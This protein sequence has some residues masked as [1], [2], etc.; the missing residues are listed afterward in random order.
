MEKHTIIRFIGILLLLISLILPAS[1]TF[2]EPTEDEETKKEESVGDGEILPGQPI[3]SPF[4]EK[5]GPEKFILDIVP[6]EDPSI[7][8]AFEVNM[9]KFVNWFLDLAFY[10]YLWLIEFSIRMINW[11]YD[12]P[13]TEEMI[14]ILKEAMPALEQAVWEPLWYLVLS[15]SFLAIVLWWGMGEEKKAISKLLAILIMLALAP[16][17][18]SWFPTMMIKV[19]ASS[20]WTSAKILEKVTGLNE[21]TRKED[22]SVVVKDDDNI[23]YQNERTEVMGV[24]WFTTEELDKTVK[25]TEA[26]HK[27]DDSLWKAFGYESYLI[28]NFGDKEIGEKYFKKLMSYGTDTDARR[29]YIKK[30]GKIDAEGKADNE[31][32]VIFTA[33]GLKERVKNTMAVTIMPLVPALSMMI[34]AF[35]ILF[36]KCLA[37][38]FGAFMVVYALLALW[39]NNGLGDFVH[40]LYKTLLALAMQVFYSIVLSVFLKIWL[41]LQDPE[42]FP[43][44][45]MGGRVIMIALIIWSFWIAAKAVR[46]KLEQVQGP[47]GGSAQGAMGSSTNELETLGGAVGTATRYAARLGGRAFKL[48]PKGYG[49]ASFSKKLASSAKGTKGAKKDWMSLRKTPQAI[50]PNLSSNANAVV[51]KMSKKNLNPYSTKDRK[52]FAEQRPD[53]KNEM[54]ELDGWMKRPIEEQFQSIP[55]FKSGNEAPPEPPKAGT[56]AYIAWKQNPE[57]QRHWKIYTEARKLI[58]DDDYSRYIKRRQRRERSIFRHM[59][60]KPQFDPE[61]VPHGKVMKEYRRL[62][63][64]T[65]HRKPI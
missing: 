28:V 14:S 2:A 17:V 57:I 13:M 42:R 52:V 23:Q 10:F 51:Q 59:L 32:F 47:F 15:F 31:D 19:N 45:N 40:Y 26:I 30:V 61:N 4:F 39:P 49:A 60:P 37:V 8:E 53:L 55:D 56:S 38:G 35:A 12:V 3:R 6:K 62:L 1:S 54:N 48:A 7:G 63:N 50:T 44:L 43:N 18:F 9:F 11:A 58:H 46:N 29:E 34:F 65:G 16:A 36:Q 24:Q 33:D 5:Y 22:E 21:L 41:S 27:I 25:T 20:T 64:R